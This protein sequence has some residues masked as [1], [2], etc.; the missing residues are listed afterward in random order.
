MERP[1]TPSTEATFENLIQESWTLMP[2][3]LRRVVPP[4][5]SQEEVR[6][7]IVRAKYFT[8]WTHWTWYVL[9]FDGNDLCFG[10]VDGDCP[11]L[12]YFSLSELA[13]IRGW[14]GW[15]RIERDLHFEPAPLSVIQKQSD[16]RP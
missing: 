5:Y 7:P 10:W 8:P 15:L 13:S 12:G 14:S 1:M 4:L 6:D 2:D 3:E 11:E 9:E 16:P